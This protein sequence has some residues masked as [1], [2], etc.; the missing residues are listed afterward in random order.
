MTTLISPA[1]FAAALTVPTATLRDGREVLLDSGP[2]L[3]L[4]LRVG[5]PVIGPTFAGVRV[6]FAETSASQCAFAVSAH[7][8]Q[9]HLAG[10]LQRP[11]IGA[12]LAAAG[13][14]HF[15]ETLAGRDHRALPWPLTVP[16]SRRR[17]TCPRRTRPSVLAIPRRCACRTDPR[18]SAS[19]R[20]A[21]LAVTSR[22]RLRSPAAQRSSPALAGGSFARLTRHRTRP[23]LHIRASPRSHYHDVHVPASQRG[24]V[25]G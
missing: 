21:A 15:A 22:A 2:W 12:A 14:S 1:S 9:L 6:I 3:G 4:R 25:R 23:G 10:A 16:P 17:R 19:A 5:E 18:T 11:L 24:D 7:L 13:A 8:R 20:T